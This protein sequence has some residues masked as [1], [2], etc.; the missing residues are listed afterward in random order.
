MK[1]S[2]T[3]LLKIPA[4][5][6]ALAFF[7]MAGATVLQAQETE[8]PTTGWCEDE[9]FGQVYKTES[10]WLYTEDHGW[11]YEIE[12]EE[13]NSWFFNPSAGWWWVN[14]NAYPWIYS[15]DENTWLFFQN[16]HGVRRFWHIVFKEWIEGDQLEEI[17]YLREVLELIYEETVIDEELVD[18]LINTLEGIFENAGML[19]EER[20]MA[21]LNQIERIFNDDHLNRRELHRLAHRLR[22]ILNAAEA[23][24]EDVAAVKEALDA[25][26]DAARAPEELRME[27]REIARTI[28]ETFREE[29]RNDEVE[30]DDES[31]GE[32]EE[33]V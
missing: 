8:E 4:I 17:E 12:G 2:K 7:L 23:T 9:A 1:R 16:R 29:R 30:E 3:D 5:K 18:N 15:N 33:T 19:E 27:A 24:E 6:A 25:I 10:G 28:V 31:K 21:F 20:V 22:R 13:G 26:I 11:L 14:R 32:D